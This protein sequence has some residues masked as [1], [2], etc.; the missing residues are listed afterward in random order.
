MT[1]GVPAQIEVH[2][3]K[4]TGIAGTA[5]ARDE[6]FEVLVRRAMPSSTSAGAGSAREES[7]KW[8]KHPSTDTG[9]D[10]SSSSLNPWSMCAAILERRGSREPGGDGGADG[11]TGSGPVLRGQCSQGASVSFPGDPAMQGDVARGAKP[12][13]KDIPS[14][15]TDSSGRFSGIGSEA[16]EHLLGDSSRGASSSRPEHDPGMQTVLPGQLEG[17]S[18]AADG[19]AHQVNGTPD[20]L[21]PV[22]DSVTAAASGALREAF[23]PTRGAN[24]NVSAGANVDERAVSQRGA[25]PSAQIGVQNN[26]Q[27]T[28]L[29]SIGNFGLRS[30]LQ[31]AKE[32]TAVALN[33]CDAQM[34]QAGVIPCPAQSVLSRDSSAALGH[35]ADARHME[36]KPL[37]GIDTTSDQQ[38]GVGSEDPLIAGGK[39]LTSELGLVKASGE[40]PRRNNAQQGK[41][42]L[43]GRPPAF[44]D[45]FTSSP[46]FELRRA[47]SVPTDARSVRD[48][49]PTVQHAAAAL[50]I[51]QSSQLRA[52]HALATSM[53]SNLQ[54]GIQTE[55]FGRVTVHTSSQGSRMFAELSVENSQQAS[56]I[57]A[58]LPEAE[59]RMETLHGLQASLSVNS[60]A[61][62]ESSQS[63]DHQRHQDS[64]PGT[65]PSRVAAGKIRGIHVSAPSEL[66]AATVQRPG[67]LNVTA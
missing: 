36:T 57:G 48:A 30:E 3:G 27:P 35:V 23:G 39:E 61:G 21:V 54:I 45:L 5:L 28:F 15:K 58:H 11:V 18:N 32:S 13:A 33:L 67:R 55:S 49:D 40:D 17:T 50:A 34:E 64:T 29:R 47:S 44:Q 51:E 19:F 7:G 6:K 1:P 62:G 22:S 9:T 63:Q 2:T 52:D 53:R 66:V 38:T 4:T 20:S 46:T 10:R 65:Y 26:A 14:G 16:C 59:H 43:S 24:G 41:E 60:S 12:F 31:A 25:V 56:V 37:P 42:S 8:K